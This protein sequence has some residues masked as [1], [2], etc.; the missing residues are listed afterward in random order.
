MGGRGFH[1][2]SRTT[3]GRCVVAAGTHSPAAARASVAGDGKVYMSE[4]CGIRGSGES[5][6]PAGRACTPCFFSLSCVCTLPVRVY[7]LFPSVYL[8]VCVI[9]YNTT[10]Y[11]GIN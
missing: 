4:V 10:E 2:I 8:S 11:L 9:L 5:A 7:I 3:T 6:M 1:G